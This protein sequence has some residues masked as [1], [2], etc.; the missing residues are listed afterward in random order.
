MPERKALL[1]RVDPAVHE[2][3]PIGPLTSCAVQRDRW[4]LSSGERSRTP[5]VCLAPS[6]PCPAWTP[7]E[8]ARGDRVGD[9]TSQL[10]YLQEE[11]CR[12]DKGSGSYWI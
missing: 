10:G 3:S 1:L 8:R 5:D 6:G 7:A 2:V 9:R 11:R 4:S 12:L